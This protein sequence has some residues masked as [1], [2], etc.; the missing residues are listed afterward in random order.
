MRILLVADIHANWSALQALEEPHDI[1]FCLGDLV[2]YGVEPAPCI[3]WVRRHAHYA[4]R[5]NHDHG[6]AQNVVVAG[7]VGF[8]Y[9]SGVTR[10]ITRERIGADDLR[11]LGNLPVTQMVTLEDT[12][13]LLV[14]ATPRD[15]MDEYAYPDPEFWARRLQNVDAD[16]ICV[17]HTHQPYVLPVGDK[18]VINP[19]S[20]GQPRDGDPRPAYAVIDNNRVEIKRF[21]YPIDAAVRSIQDSALPDQAKELLAEVLR[22]G[23]GVRPLNGAGAPAVVRTP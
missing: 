13:F 19:G 16:V 8:K 21:E 4:V 17:G 3:D 9:L 14:H 23:R 7:R 2:D 22:I 11:F 12:R 1:C 15:P 18:L 6:T 20:A 5:G 10:Q